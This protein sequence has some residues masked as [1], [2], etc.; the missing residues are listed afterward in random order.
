MNLF[1]SEEHARNWA[2]FGPEDGLVPLEKVMAWFSVSLWR[3]RLNGEYVSH[4]AEYFEEATATRRE[5]LGDNPF[6]FP[7]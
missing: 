6:W 4:L 2:G 1:R 7:A 3:E 5:I